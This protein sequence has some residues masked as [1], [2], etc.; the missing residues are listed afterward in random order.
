MNRRSFIA[1]SFSASAVLGAGVFGFAQDPSVAT[2]PTPLARTPELKRPP[3]LDPESVRTFVA[4]GHRDLPKIKELLAKEPKL[5]NASLDLGGGDWESALGAASHV[6]NR[7]IAL[8]L[9]AEGARPDAFC[10]AMLGE[11]DFIT[12]LMRFSPASANAR[13]PHGLTLMYH[14]G[15]T[16]NVAMAQVVGPHVKSRRDFNQAL[17]S[18][19]PNGK[20]E[21]VA[22]LLGYGADNVNIKSFGKTPLDLAV[23][24]GHGE[25]ADHLRA[26]GARSASAVPN[27]K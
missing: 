9:L 11:M 14:I 19:V 26:A 5:I 8:H 22:W 3:A 4:A 6:G 17:L 18:A 27:E 7:A 21:L 24:N 15:Y 20:T 16:G 13:G 1:S 2:P 10:A 12:A 23:E 25:I